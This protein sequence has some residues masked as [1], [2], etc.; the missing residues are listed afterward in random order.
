[1]LTNSRILPAAILLVFLVSVFSI[2]GTAADPEADAVAQTIVQLR[3]H[4]A[5]GMDVSPQVQTLL[6][7][8]KQRIRALVLSELNRSS[9]AAPLDT[10]S[11][12]VNIVSRLRS[13]GVRIGPVP[14]PTGSPSPSDY[15]KP[16]FGHIEEISLSVPANNPGLVL[17]LIKFELPCGSDFS[18]SGFSK[19]ND[20]WNTSFVR[21]ENDYSSVTGAIG[22][23]TF[24]VSVPN[25]TNDF[26]VVSAAV[27][28]CTQPTPISFTLSAIKVMSQSGL[29]SEL[30]KTTDPQRVQTALS[31]RASISTEPD[32]F[33]IGFQVA[34]FLERGQPSRR[35][36]IRFVARDGSLV[37]TAPR[38]VDN[39]RLV[40]F[41]DEWMALPLNQASP[42]VSGIAGSIIAC[43]HDV[44]RRRAETAATPQFLGLTPS[45]SPG[46]QI[47][48]VGFAGLSDTF[49]ISIGL[50]DGVGTILGVNTTRPNCNP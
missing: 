11:A 20:Q 37:Q 25:Q 44:I 40:E 50:K 43:R 38:I 6:T 4:D 23:L 18:L 39:D 29:S 27:G 28:A 15:V 46:R 8:I 16:A 36:T 9:T 33:E 2:S 12:R 34:K 30:F 1:M 45:C 17:S 32:S 5:N 21:E 49:Y 14:I 24:Q 42:W 13:A 47:M 22:E 41:V 7:Q 19:A 3:S 35:R 48:A 26:L 10:A 31:T